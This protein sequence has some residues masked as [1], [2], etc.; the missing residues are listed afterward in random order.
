MEKCTLT[1]RG[2]Y[3]VQSMEMRNIS[4]VCAAHIVIELKKMVLWLFFIPFVV[5]TV[6]CEISF[7]SHQCHRP[8]NYRNA[9]IVGGY[10]A[11]RDESSYLAVLT[12]SG[13]NIFCGSAIISER[14]ILTAAH[15]VCNNKN[16]LIQPT[17]MK[18]YVGVH[19]I[20]DIQKIHENS[21]DDGMATE[22]IV[23]KIIVHSGYTCGK[24]SDKDIG[25]YCVKFILKEHVG[26]VRMNGLRSSQRRIM[27]LK[28]F[29]LVV[30]L[31][32]CH[33]FTQN[34]VL[35]EGT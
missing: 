17:Q 3:K 14:F 9:R 26:V 29:T 31:V 28:L 24:K 32:L 4:R 12:R 25:L 23:E 7:S 19:D 10:N 13:G 22:V 5:S 11:R 18:V 1:S 21:I 27:T 8:S 15:C 35:P 2:I 16:K 30:M 20:S 6:V 34:Y 33:F